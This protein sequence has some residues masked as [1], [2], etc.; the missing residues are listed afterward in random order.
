MSFPTEVM[1][2]SVQ[3]RPRSGTSGRGTSVLGTAYEERC[4]MEADSSMVVDE[5]GQEVR[6][7]LWGV[8][9]AECPV[10]PGDEITYYS[11]VYRC[12]KVTPC[13]Q[14]GNPHHIE[15]MFGGLRP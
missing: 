9:R 5:K 13:S 10:Q 11:R 15:A 1:T 3:I 2:D 6:S 8:F 12:L 4:Y 7:A 14:G